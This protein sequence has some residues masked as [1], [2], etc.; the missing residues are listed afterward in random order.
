AYTASTDRLAGRIERDPR[1]AVLPYTTLF[2][3]HVARARIAEARPIPLAIIRRYGR[4]GVSRAAG[5]GNI[6]EGQA[7]IGAHLPLHTRR[8][9]AARGHLGT[10]TTS[11]DRLPASI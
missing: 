3:S 10:P 11:T 7:A 5:P 8:G 9:C 2:R 6:R 1:P 4:E